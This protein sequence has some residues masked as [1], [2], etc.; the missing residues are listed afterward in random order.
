MWFIKS[1]KKVSSKDLLDKRL[2]LGE[3]N[4]KEYV[5]ILNTLEVKNEK[6]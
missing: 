4:K 1:A 5:N 3:I 2:A 6:D